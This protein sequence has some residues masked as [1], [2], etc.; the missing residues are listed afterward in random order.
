MLKICRGR[1]AEGRDGQGG[2]SLDARD[3][4]VDFGPGDRDDL[5]WCWGSGRKENH[6]T[7]CA[8]DR[9]MREWICEGKRSGKGGLEP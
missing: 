7:R 1:A 3:A 9:A 6:S 2:E 8:G 5:G 4:G